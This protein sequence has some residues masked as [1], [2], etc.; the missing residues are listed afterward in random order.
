MTIQPELW[1][2]GGET[3]ADR[4]AGLDPD[5]QAFIDIHGP[6]PAA[7]RDVQFVELA[8]DVL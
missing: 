1:H 2:D 4:K 5:E 6:A 3:E 8:L 7:Y